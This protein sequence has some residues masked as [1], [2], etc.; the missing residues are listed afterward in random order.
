MLPKSSE[1]TQILETGLYLTSIESVRSDATILKKSLKERWSR[2]LE[3]IS[4]SDKL[5]A[6]MKKK[7]ISLYMDKFNIMAWGGKSYHQNLW[8]SSEGEQMEKG[9]LTD[10]IFLHIQKVFY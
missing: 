10:T 1:E 3:V 7:M 5:L 6:T 8:R 2:K 9:D 4:T